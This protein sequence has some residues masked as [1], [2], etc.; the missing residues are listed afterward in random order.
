MGRLEEYVEAVTGRLRPDRE[1]HMDVA[2]EVR[3][4]IED[5]AEEARERGLGEDAAL[6]AA[7]EAFG[8]RERM[9]EALWEANRH[10]MRLRAVIKWALR[11]TLVPAALALSVYVCGTYFIGLCQVSQL[12]GDLIGG[13]GWLPL[14]RVELPELQPRSDLTPD[15]RFIFDNIRDVPFEEDIAAVRGLADRF[16]NDPS[17]Y[18]Q[19]V[20]VLLAR[21]LGLRHSTGEDIL[22][23]LL[24]ILDK[25]EEVEPDNA[26]YNYLRAALLI[27]HSSTYEKEKGICFTYT[28]ENGQEKKRCGYSLT[29]T[30]PALID[31]AIQE[32]YKGVRKPYF[33]TRVKD[34]VQLRLSLAKTPAAFVEDLTS[35]SI[36]AATRL[37]YLSL[38]RDMNEC[39]PAYASLLASEG[40]REDAVR[41]L[42][43]IDRPAQQMAAGAQISI[44]FLV[45]RACCRRTLGQAAP[46][47]EKLDMPERAAEARREFERENELWNSLRQNQSSGDVPFREVQKYYGILY[48]GV[49]PG[50]P[51]MD[52]SAIGRPYALLE[53]VLLEEVAL[54]LLLAVLV[55]TALILGARTY[56]SMWKRRRQADGPKL[57]FV[58]WRRLG[59]IVLIS[60][61]VPIGLYLAYTRLM[62][63]SSME[64]GLH[65]AV[66]RCALELSVLFALVSITLMATSYEA[67]RQRCREAGIEVPEPGY[68]IPF[69]SPAAVLGAL[70]LVGVVILCLALTETGGR[71]RN[72]VLFAVASAVFA[73]AIVYLAQQHWL[74][75]RAYS[76]SWSSAGCLLRVVAAIACTVFALCTGA[77]SLLWARGTAE[78]V[79]MVVVAALAVVALLYAFL[80]GQR[81][82]RQPAEPKVHFHMTFLRSLV[83][84][85]TVCLLVLGLGGNAYLRGAEAA[86]ARRLNEPGPLHRWDL[87]MEGF[88]SYQDHMREL[89]REWLE[90]HGENA[91]GPG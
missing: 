30:D 24:P 78:A 13:G 61:A 7:L 8:D 70:L 53:H 5:A 82:D 80:G 21:D 31:R 17:L 29:V 25:A 28:D 34:A 39:L 18:A 10:R 47:Y 91:E 55:L 2:H 85:L 41:L 58:G 68:F 66:G 36:S 38:M 65:Y 56:W 23:R 63:F 51:G 86:Q 52:H 43:A 89:N 50:M 88:R 37:S 87:E 6:D 19:Y 71:W 77:F 62:P 42:E 40:D 20:K 48:L 75:R 76:S 32:I 69:R 4:H 9:A 27:K 83:P 22:P 74:L 72:G 45:A 26:Y 57:F 60:L 73:G 35:Y 46:I 54:G 84:I 3:A 14:P 49:A 64:Y 79:L 44:E 81:R 59:W 1:L 90:S 11:A 12:Y 67:I 33:N 16:P 15:E